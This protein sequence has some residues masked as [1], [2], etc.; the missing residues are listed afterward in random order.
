LSYAEI[1]KSMTES[2]L[3]KNLG[4]LTKG[5]DQWEENIAETDSNRVVRIHCLGAV[6]AADKARKHSD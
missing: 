4:T 3:Y 6:K 2:E 1:I 5:K